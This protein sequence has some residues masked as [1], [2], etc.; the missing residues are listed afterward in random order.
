M[1]RM[2]SP[3]VCFGVTKTTPASRRW[4]WWS[5]PGDLVSPTWAPEGTRVAFGPPPSWKRADGIGAVE[6]L[7]DTSS[8]K[9]Q[10]FSPEGTILVWGTLKPRRDASYNH[11]ERQRT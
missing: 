2:Q 3:T 1:I 8:R 4:V 10:A 9:P 7:D 6:V 11:G 5:Q